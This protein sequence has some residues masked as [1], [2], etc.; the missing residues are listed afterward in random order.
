[1]ASNQS[2]LATAQGLYEDW[3]KIRNATGA[4]VD[5]ADWYL[6]DDPADLRKWRFPSFT[7]KEFDRLRR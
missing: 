2:N 1:M 4:A 6:T 7:E 3:L 5:L